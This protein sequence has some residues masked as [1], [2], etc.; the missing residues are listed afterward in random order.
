MKNKKIKCLILGLI[1]I[2]LIVIVYFFLKKNDTIDLDNKIDALSY[3]MKLDLDTKN[4]VLNEKVEMEIKNNTRKSI[5]EIVIRDMTKSLLKYYKENYNKE[6]NNKSEILGIKE[7]D[8]DLKYIIE[9]DSIVKVKLNKTLKPNDTVKINVSIK[10]D[11]PERQDRFGYIKR[12]DGY[13]YALSFCFPYLADNID[14]KWILNPYF[15]D[16]ENRSYDLADYEIE[17]K[18]PSDY[19]IIA[20]GKEEINNGISKITAKNIRDIAIVLSDMYKKDSFEVEGVK[21]NNYYLESKYTSMYRKLT[22]LVIEDSIKV[23]T[24]EVGKYPYDELDVVPLLFGFGYGGMEYPGLIMTN[25]TSFYDGT[26]VDPWSLF[27][28]LSHEIAHQWFYGTVGNNEYSEAWIDEG[29]TTYLERQLFSLYEGKAHKYLLEID[30]YAPDHKGRIEMREE[31][32]ET[33][34]EDFKGIYLNVSPDEYENDRSYG[35]GEYEA[36]YCF[37]QEIRMAMGDD[38]FSK[39]LKDFYKTYYLKTVNTDM[40]LKLIREYDNSKKINEIID[41]YFK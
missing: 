28:G 15:D 24:D 30:E 33:A 19:A 4:K 2:G 22:K 12:N 36:S 16:G 37:I 31:M 13:I 3:N 7:N 38:K 41:F 39:F 18:H 10:T 40:V 1:I 27:D 14:G 8:I 6:S 26:L 29:F 9:K 17:I 34:R 23:F 5:D 35:E 20:T 11:I 21:I 25:A 32:L